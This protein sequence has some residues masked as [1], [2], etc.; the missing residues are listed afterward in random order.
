MTSR[1]NTL[2]V[3]DTIRP[4]TWLGE[5]PL[6]AAFNLL[7]VACS[8]IAF[9]LPFTP[10]PVTGQTFGVLLVAMALGRMRAGIVTTAYL[11]EGAL[12]LPVFA[13]GAGSV[14][15]LFG[16]TGGYL[17]GFLV[18]AVLV[19]YLAEKGWDRTVTS[20]IAA[21]LLGYA[22]IFLCGLAM[23]ARFVPADQILLA[24]FYPYLPGTAV[25]IGLACWVLPLIRSRLDSH[26]S[27]L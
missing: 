2:T 20:S 16:P 8:Y 22:V 25:K 4:Q 24:G 23:L 11:L 19:G 21:M 9:P 14:A 18:A 1:S 26:Q 17:F 7:L 27:A 13:G 12:G 15:V 10:V 5:L 6:L 3:Y